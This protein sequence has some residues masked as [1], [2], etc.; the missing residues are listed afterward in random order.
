MRQILTG[1]AIVFFVTLAVTPTFA[2]DS[3]ATTP[4]GAVETGA[5]RKRPVDAIAA[6]VNDDIILSS[7][8]EE[9][10]KPALNRL[11]GAPAGPLRENEAYKIRLDALNSLIVDRIM[12]AQVAELHL[13]VSDVEVTQAIDDVKK[14]RGLDDKAL[15]AAIEGEGLSFNDYREVVK[16]HLVKSKLFAIKVRPRVKVTDEDVKNWYMQNVNAAAASSGMKL[17]AIFVAFPKDPKP[18]ALQEARSRAGEAFAKAARGEDFSA[19]AAQYSDDATAK[20]GGDMGVV[21]KGLLNPVL[22][23]AAFALKEGQV[24]EP[25]ETDAGI[26]VLKAVKVFAGEAKPLKDVKDEIFRR[27]FEDE[28]EKQFRLWLDEIRKDAHIEIMLKKPE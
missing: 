23:R 16:G 2:A 10:A 19:L 14:Q 1:A 9:R 8:L 12:K 27:L 18:G 5:G 28:S 24:S 21:K 3:K 11:D 4:S 25:V 15:R 22:D 13:D 20:S 17:A 7:E 26:Y 6:V